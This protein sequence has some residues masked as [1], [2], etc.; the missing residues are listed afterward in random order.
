MKLTK[1][2]A[3]AGLLS[4]LM[5]G[6][7]GQV[8]S[9]PG[10]GTGGSGSSATGG[11]TGTGGSK[12]SGSNSGGT[13][14]GGST[15]GSGGS[16]SGTGATGSGTGGATLLN[17]SAAA[18]GRSP[19]RRLTIFEY[20]NTVR[21]LLG[22]T[23]NPANDFPSEAL[24]N[25][26][27][28]D[29]DSQSV[30][31]VLA[32][33][34]G[35]V[36]AD[37][38]AHATADSTALGKLATC[39][40]NVTTANED[41]CAKTFITAFLP[42]AYRRAVTSAEIDDYVSL[43]KTVRGLSTTVN[44][45]SGVAA[46]I[47]AVLQAPDFLYRLE[48]GTTDPSNPNIKKLTGRELA[49]RL[50][51]FLWETMPDAQLSSDA[52]AGML[53]TPEGIKTAAT[54]LLDD[55]KSHAVVSFFFDNL[56][57]LSI[58][59][60]LERDKTTYPT[61]S[62]TVGASMRK[63]VERL[64]EYE[65]YENTAPASGSAYP[66]GSWPALLT[67][68]YT[69]VDQ[70]LFKFYGASAFSNPPN[71]TGTTFQKVN[72]N[73]SQRLGLL[74]LGGVMAGTTTTNLTNP[75]LRGSYIVQKLMCRTIPLPTGDIL[76][77]VKPPDPYS[78]KTARERF[79]QHSAQDVC[80]SCHQ[81]MDPVGLTFE[82]YDAVGLYRTSEHTVIDGVAYDT[83]ID[84]SGSL[85]GVTGTA[86]NGIDLVKL[87]ASSEE[88][89]NCMA[90]HWMEFG[91]GRLLDSTADGCNKQNLQAAFKSSGYKL[92]DLLLSLTQT[93]GFMYRAT[94]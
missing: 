7:V 26:F 49:T 23:R 70:T 39:A 8:S 79:G 40:S 52:D 66:A 28:N 94:Q 30:P 62:S 44:F 24:G 92:K 2:S 21:D 58:L 63:E 19:L 42:K 61:F 38:A 12:T 67:S 43:Y 87:L 22:D 5:A 74:T 31:S 46:V 33:S 14:G 82:N 11:S 37:I 57:P 64:I 54:R 89:Q 69:F 34:Y 65:M 16:A 47:E 1:I 86:A 45:A 48:F 71:V 51:Y 56:L 91:Y 3:V 20:N 18:P 41:S 6:C 55:Q 32:D 59:T 10:G 36:A 90:T 27:G 35:T 29:A 80:H 25:G 60:G 76:A 4:W 93:D 73:T 13:S 53:S 15:T 9:D 77:M 78:G 88:A 85:P 68:P 84:A 83:P 50:S 81:F 75:V 72:L 17:C